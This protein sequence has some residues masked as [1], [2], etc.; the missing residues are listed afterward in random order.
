VNEQQLLEQRMRLHEV[1]A[2]NRVY[3]WPAQIKSHD[4]L[5][6]SWGLRG[7]SMDELKVQFSNRRIV[8]ASAMCSSGCMVRQN[9]VM[10]VVVDTE[11][12]TLSQS[13]KINLT[14]ET[15]RGASAGHLSDKP[16]SR[17]S[18]TQGV[19]VSRIRS[20]NSGERRVSWLSRLGA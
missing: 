3:C 7:P 18:R 19:P 4:A 12:L 1:G 11:V 8:N 2:S 20:Y 6:S 9:M 5:E 16:Q 10:K 14:I 15:K 17:T 13:L